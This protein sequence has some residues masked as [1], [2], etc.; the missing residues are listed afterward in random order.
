MRK[1][2]ALLLAA[3]LPGI[4][5]AG[6]KKEM[7]DS[8]TTIQLWH[9]YSGRNEASLNQIITLF[10]AQNPDIKV[11]VTPTPGEFMELLQKMIADIAAGN[12]APD[13]FIGGYNLLE[14]I[15]S[16]MEPTRIN[17]LAP[18]RTAYRNFTEKF[19][20]GMLKLGE[21]NREQISIPFGLTNF[22]MYYNE[23]LFKA[24]GLTE[25]DVPKTWDDVIRV[26]R[27]IKE[28]TGK[29]AIALWKGTAS[30]DICL[31]NSNGG[32]MLTDDKTQV[33]FNNP[34]TIEAIRF[35]QSLNQL[36][37]EQMST[38]DEDMTNFIA[39]EVAMY[40][41]VCSMLASL[42]R[43][44]NFNLKVA[45]VPAFG[46]KRKALP[47][48]GG[49]I[50]SFTKDR[51]KYDAVWRFINF[52]TDPE[53]MEIRTGTGALCTTNADV[54]I[55]PGQEPAYAQMQYMIP[56][57]NWPGGAAGLEIDRMY[58]N[59]R[60]EI[61]RSNVDVAAAL[62]QLEDDCNRLLADNR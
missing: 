31:I 45:E 21:I 6:G 60:T 1:G 34:E 7:D 8:V 32:K 58:L 41:E 43:S 17:D 52:A 47:A 5:F 42:T 24:A 55:V 59:K 15:Y 40:V 46:N 53:A 30:F 49:T 19:L 57:L 44:S 20:P 35:W 4:L 11:E 25:A 28:Q 61:I 10:E 50:M 51:T 14:Y 12:P 56:M 2:I 18:N 13:L 3:M 54:P 16:E 62:R 22:V 39:G 37:L 29:Y 48:Q 33:A 36:G 9:R 38:T 23:D 26:G 27:I